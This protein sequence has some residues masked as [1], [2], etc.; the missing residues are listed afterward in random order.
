MCVANLEL[1]TQKA[2]AFPMD[3]DD[4]YYCIRK[5]QEPEWN[6]KWY[7][8]ICRGWYQAQETDSNFTMLSNPYLFSS[9]I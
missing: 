1:A 5:D 9:D 6:Q 2:Y 8:P 4:N 7:S 3:H